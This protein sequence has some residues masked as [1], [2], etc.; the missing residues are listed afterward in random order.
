[1]LCDLRQWLCADLWEHSSA[2][3]AS[4]VLSGLAACPCQALHLPS[5]HRHQNCIE[6]AVRLWVTPGLVMRP[7][8]SWKLFLL[9]CLFLANH[10]GHYHNTRLL[11]LCYGSDKSWRMRPCCCVQHDTTR[12]LNLC[13]GSDKSWRMCPCCCAQ[14]DAR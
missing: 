10:L 3:K 14:H 9:R 13:Y 12:L 4:P 7:C 11:N 6:L 2:W 5:L 1:M 8:T